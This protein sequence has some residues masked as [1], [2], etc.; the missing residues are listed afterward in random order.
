MTYAFKAGYDGD[1]RPVDQ[2]IAD[3]ILT[4]RSKRR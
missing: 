1:S 3:F 2:V 4:N